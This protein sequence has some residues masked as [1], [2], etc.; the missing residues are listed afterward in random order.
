[1]EHIKNII[2]ENRS[3][4]ESDSLP[5]GHKRRFFRKIKKKVNSKDRLLNSQSKL[6]IYSMAA[7]VALAF[8]I[9]LPL[10]KYNRSKS[11][12][13]A[14]GNSYVAILN[15]RNAVILS[16]IGPLDPLDRELVLNTLDQLVQEAIPFEEQLPQNMDWEQKDILAQRYYCPKIEGMEKLKEYVSQL[17]VL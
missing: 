10:F 14:I 3:V 5:Q 13:N 8:I 11:I 12:E 15:E 17:L 6:F 16:M 4:F 2:A 1:M 7:A 9:V